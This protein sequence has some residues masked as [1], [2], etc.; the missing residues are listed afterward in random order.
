MDGAPPRA[1]RIEGTIRLS[2]LAKAVTVTLL[3]PW[4]SCAGLVMD[5]LRRAWAHARLAAKI[6]VPVDPSAIILDVPEIH[7]LYLET[8]GEG[9]I[10]IGDDVVM[11]RGTHT[12]AFANVTIGDGTMIGEYTSIRDANHRV[13]TGSAIRTSGHDARPIVSGRNVWIGR[14]VAVLLG[15]TIGDR[16]L[17]GANATVSHDVPKD[18]TVVGVPA[19]PIAG[20]RA[21]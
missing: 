3:S 17:V 1:D 20:R 2:H 7:E 8:Q 19:R 11:S 15:V 10:S 13:G 18:M 12:V 6:H 4:A 14:R 21:E 5:P 16:A 9:M